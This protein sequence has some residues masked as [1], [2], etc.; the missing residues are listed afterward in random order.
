[1]SMD[2]QRLGEALKTYGNG[3]EM[4]TSDVDRMQRDL[5]DRL[6][7]GRGPRRSRIILAA[8]AVLLLVAGV[9]GGTVWLRRP[10]TTAPAVPSGPSGWGTQD[11]MWFLSAQ[12]GQ[13]SQ[14]GQPPDALA[15]VR[16]AG[17]ESDFPG[18][19]P[20]VHPVTPAPAWPWRMEGPNYVL[21]ATDQQGQ[22]CRN[23][24]ARHD[25]GD[26]RTDFDSA[27]LDGPGC[28]GATSAPPSGAFRLSPVSEASVEGARQ[29]LDARSGNTVTA[30]MTDPV[31]LDGIWLLA[32]TGVLLASDEADSGGSDYLLDDDGDIDRNPDV[33][34]RLTVGSDGRITLT[35]SACADTVMA[36]TVLRGATAMTEL[37]LTATV[38]ADP[39]NRF[40]GQTALT[41]IRVL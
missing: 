11:G 3:V 29:V 36:N 7:Q 32:G 15:S 35:S 22:L 28:G 6:G 4:T 2:T 33:R 21:D 34:G 16:A 5:H 27:T 18:A 25:Q 12:S 13:S 14:S 24:A 23:T 31:Q 20:L 37:V 8:A 17:T 40:G 38:D 10:D 39:C 26:G 30:P 19:Q 41:W 9:V 1:M